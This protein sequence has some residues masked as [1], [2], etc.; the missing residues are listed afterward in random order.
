MKYTEEF[1]IK[2]KKETDNLLHLLQQYKFAGSMD[3]KLDLNIIIRI[4]ANYDFIVKNLR[5]DIKEL[6]NKIKE[7]NN[8]VEE[9]E[10]EKI[11]E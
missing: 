11:N 6:D 2:F 3:T 9:L 10:K 5:D 1:F 7:L 8:K 4:I